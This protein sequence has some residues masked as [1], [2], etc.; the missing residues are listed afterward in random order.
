MKHIT[1]SPWVVFTLCLLSNSRIASDLR[2]PVVVD[3]PVVVI[4]RD[5]HVATIEMDF[6]P[7]DAY[8]LWD[9]G[10]DGQ[11]PVGYLVQWWPDPAAVPGLV[12]VCGCATDQTTGDTIIGTESQP[13]KLVTANRVAQIQP[14]ANNVLYHV[15]VT[16][17]NSLGALC[18]P[19]TTLTFMGGDPTR[20]NALRNTMTFFD[21]FNL[22]EGPADER[23]WNNAMTPQ[24][25]P[26]FN[27]FFI[28]PQC[29]THTLTGTSN[30]AAGDRAQVAQRPRKPILIDSVEERRIV[31]DMDGLFSPRSV[32]YL[33]L[34]PV[35]TDLTGHMSFFDEDGD[36]GLPADVLR[37]RAQYNEISVHLINAQGEA[38]H[39]ASAN[40]ADFGRRPC[41]NVRRSFDVRVNTAG[42]K[43]YVDSVL[44]IN[45][46]FAPGDFKPGIY[47]LLWS[48]IGYNTSKD[49]NPYFLS[50]WDNFGFDGP[51]VEPFIVHNYVSRIDS[52]DY[53]KSQDYNEEYPMYTIH[54]PDDI[55]PLTPAVHNDVY[56]VFTYFSNDYSFFNIEPGDSV[57]VNGVGYPLPE[58][59]N[60]SVPLN[61]DLVGYSGSAISNRIH[62]GEA[63]FNEHSPLHVGHN[64][65]QFFA[66]NAGILNVHFEVF[67][68]S[69]APEPPYTQP[70]V[71]H[72]HFPMHH[73][74]PKLGIP[75]YIIDIDDVEI[76]ADEDENLFGP[77]VSGIVPVEVM[78]GN[79][80]WANWA[81]NLLNMPAISAE[82]WSAG[83]T[84][85]VESL[86]FFIKPALDTIAP[87]IP[88]ASVDVSADHPAPQI[89]YAYA[90]NSTLWANGLYDIFVQATAPSGLK[91]HPAYAGFAHTWDAAEISGAYKS[92][93][94]EI[95]NPDVFG[96]YI[97]TG[98][99]DS[100]WTNNAN[101]NVGKYPPYYHHGL[102]RIEADCVVPEGVFLILGIGGECILEEGVELRVRHD[103]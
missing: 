42:I 43:I 90:F 39:Q 8:Q 97:F 75:A 6:D 48:T 78:A 41:T 102:I 63:H 86:H 68:P 100:L 3:P 55:R 88:F 58:G 67:C 33:D 47:N 65:V 30:T 77:T 85:G 52:T 20:V 98:A 7:S 70:A 25:D 53:Q 66:S 4:R 17:L 56:L 19:A 23:N 44:V 83:S 96:E 95:N 93:R 82:L 74:L 59:P 24:T 18:S 60:N 81:P 72:G 36:A 22:P 71:V 89:R 27:L 101:W 103:D 29:H 34:N 9:V 14:I 10:H 57:F 40:L 11:D 45:T 2:M 37:L 32:W 26:R 15:R 49:D 87:G 79:R 12:A 84:P 21:D 50:H 73:D 51:D 35:K 99:V 92:V 16:K 38:Y 5:D 13:H 80:H 1:S 46:P 76:E 62:I 61:P 28:N 94:I 91:S 69:N 64:E 54:V 31:F